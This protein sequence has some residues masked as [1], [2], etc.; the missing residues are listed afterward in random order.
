MRLGGGG[1]FDE[2]RGLGHILLDSF[3]SGVVQGAYG[4]KHPLRRSNSP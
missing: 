2:C 1:M 4:L 3:K